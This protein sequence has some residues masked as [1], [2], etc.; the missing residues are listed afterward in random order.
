MAKAKTNE[1][2]RKPFHEIV[3]DR[4]IELLKQGTAPWQKPWE[5]G[6]PAAVFPMNPTTGQRYKG[7]NAIFLMAQGHDDLRWM[8]YRQ[9]EAVGAQVRKGE[10]GTPIQYW[11]FDDEAPKVDAQ[12]QPVRNA[13]GVQE[14]ERVR[15]ERPRVFH[16][17]VFNATQIDGLPPMQ[18]PNPA[19]QRWSAVERAETILA[20][21][22]AAIRH[23]SGNRAFYRM[24]SDSIHL[25][26]PSQFPSADRYYATAL[27][28][29]GHWTG[30][31]LR[32]G[33][34]LSHPFG[35]EAYAKEELRA[36]IASMIL[37]D[38]LGIGHDPGQHAAY[39][40]SWITVLEND[41][42]EIVRAASDA[43]K[44]QRFVLAFE[45]V[46]Q[47]VPVQVQQGAEAVPQNPETPSV[48]LTPRPGLMV[49]TEG[50][51]GR[52]QD[53]LVD[54]GMAVADAVTAAAWRDLQAGS[55]ASH[56]GDGRALGEASQRAFGFALPADWTGRVEVHVEGFEDNNPA[57]DEPANGQPSERYSVQ[58]QRAGGSFQHLQ[59]LRAREEA[60][61]VLQRL[62]LIDAHAEIDRHEQAA[63]LARLKDEV[64]RRNPVSVDGPRDAGR[65]VSHQASAAAVAA[66]PTLSASA[67]QQGVLQPAPTS[68]TE[69]TDTSHPLSPSKPER[70]SMTP[71]K[72]TFLTVPFR[73]KDQVKALGAKWDRQAQSWYVPAGVDP[74]P[75]AKW[76]PTTSM[77]M[78]A[79]HGEQAQV[80]AASVELKG[81]EGRQYLAVPYADRE[82]AKA[83]GAEWDRV[84]KSWFI[85]PQANPAQL[86]RWVPNPL[87]AEQE[88]AMHPR[89][90]FAEAMRHHG[91]VVEGDHPIMD[92]HK[93]RVPV[94]GGKKGA[95]DGFY[96][97]FGDGHPAGRI[98]NHKTGVD[99]K[100]RSKGYT[101]SPECRARLQAEAAA[102]MA[103]RAAAQAIQHEQAATRV[104]AQLGTL[105]PVTELT[106]Y[107]RA[108]GVQAHPGAFTD[109]EGKTTYI[110]AIDTDNR[111]W[112]M[113][114]ILEDGTKRFAK[115]SHKEACFHA[116]GGLDAL[117]KA[118]AIVLGEGYATAATLCEALGFAT[119]AAFD[120]GN[121]AAV[122]KALQAKFPEKPIVIAGDDDHHREVTNGRNPGVEQMKE[123]AAAVGAV[124]LLPIFAPGERDAQPAALTDFNDLATKSMLGRDGVERQ[125]RGVV[126]AVVEKH[127]VM[128]TQVHKEP[129]LGQVLPGCH[130]LGSHGNQ[131]VRQGRAA[132]I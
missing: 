50:Q 92:G 56:A 32:L 74:A 121:L 68:T 97:L 65:P 34:D 125:V 112:S 24:A 63:K 109:A 11:K 23:D 128:R 41:P 53:R 52:L 13:Q 115:D 20:A 75:F 16:A 27:H 61:V 5:P 110:P 3:A 77:P 107:L 6:Q 73:Q 81:R 96:V 71:I 18:R 12:G 89:D 85:G 43:E 29:L 57:P 64:T 122:A 38:T 99:E 72:A 30:H 129:E 19:E 39:V 93:H 47:L 87:V 95:V 66:V 76:T 124:E 103:R 15:L 69:R 4:L 98:I 78:P 42:L 108:K 106:P 101:F 36:E 116:V 82:A 44:I 86:Q 119:V 28:E 117:A 118:P 54:A 126:Q 105:Q 70:E 55:P 104:V 25:P 130:G 62:G 8:T 111:V 40:K 33:R 132:R 51:V 123:A 14:T 91:L 80:S 113:Q 49:S 48:Q 37:G 94:E 45:Q 102:N 120:A 90:E 79:L 9:A 21:S 26:L 2:R 114:Y 58:A 59:T 100:W 84:L 1:Q 83:A 10:R 60:E 67:E 22:G 127:L 7:I 131:S 88:P 17:T 35:S 46:Q 31:A